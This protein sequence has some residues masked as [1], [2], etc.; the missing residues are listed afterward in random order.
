MSL[1]IRIVL[2][3]CALGLLVFVLFNIRKSKLR[4]EDS[5][6]WFILSAF[7]L[8]L[9]VFPGIAS[10]CSRFFKFQ[11][12]VNFVFLAFIAIL[13]VKCFTM[14]IRVSHLET[15]LDELVQRIAIAQRDDELQG[16]PLEVREAH[17]GEDESGDEPR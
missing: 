3:I 5:L 14:S 10:T 2:I 9:A 4:I 1:G 6:F 13:L 16:E 7:I 17:D 8:L 12:P 11:A 15:K